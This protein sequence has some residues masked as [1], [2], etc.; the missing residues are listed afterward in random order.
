MPLTLSGALL[1]HVKSAPSSEWHA[2]GERDEE[3]EALL[4]ELMA[5]VDDDVDE[6]KDDWPEEVDADDDERTGA[7]TWV[8][9]G[10]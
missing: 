8:K 10:E 1:A 6:A 5:D 4:E 9:P 7:D 3:F 2:P